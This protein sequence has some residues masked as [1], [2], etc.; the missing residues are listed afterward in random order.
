M[1]WI[2]IGL[3]VAVV[4][5]GLGAAWVATQGDDG[6]AGMY[7]VTVT[8]PDGTLFDAV[9]EVTAPTAL[10]ALDAASRSGGFPYMTRQYPQF[11]CGTYVSSIDGHAEQG[12]Y[13]WV[14]EV[15]RDGGRSRPPMASCAFALAPGDTVH[16]LWATE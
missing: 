6:V 3:L 9:V 2:T 7:R 16:W 14:Y 13:G 4:A 12:A 11:G 10:G 5:A 1:R 8:S 15:E